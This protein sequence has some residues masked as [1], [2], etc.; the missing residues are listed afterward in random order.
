MTRT[1]N[2]GLKLIASSFQDRRRNSTSKRKI[3]AAIRLHTN[4]GAKLILRPYFMHSP[5]IHG[6]VLRFEYWRKHPD[7]GW[8][9]RRGHIATGGNYAFHH[10]DQYMDIRETLREFAENPAKVL[11]RSTG[12]CSICDRRLTD[13]VSQARGVGP[14]CMKHIAWFIQEVQSC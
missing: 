4:D 13:P 6:E 3:K 14:E 8:I 1:Y 5:A 10:G 7:I 9:V 12:S 2:D 11:R